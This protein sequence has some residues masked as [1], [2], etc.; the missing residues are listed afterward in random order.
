ML[1]KIRSK[2]IM[3]ANSSWWV[4]ELLAAD[5]GK[6]CLHEGLEDTMQKWYDWLGEMQKKDEIKKVGRNASTKSEPDD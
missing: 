4:S 1:R 2:G 6:A 5:C 3:E